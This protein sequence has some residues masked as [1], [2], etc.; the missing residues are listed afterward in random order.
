MF[1]VNQTVL[2]KRSRK[3]DPTVVSGD[4][5]I[6]DLIFL[7][8]FLRFFGEKIIFHFSR[9]SVRNFHFSKKKYTQN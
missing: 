7:S 9:K 8:F 6:Q 4:C 1:S 3:V 2:S 5:G